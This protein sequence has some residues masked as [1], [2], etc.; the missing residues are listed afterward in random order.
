MKKLMA[1]LAGIGL[2]AGVAN[3]DLLV[4]WDFVGLSGINS[5]SITANVA[6]A[7]MA[8][9]GDMLVDRGA[10]L[11]PSSNTGGYAANNWHSD[12][13][14]LATAI[15]SNNYFSFTLEAAD[16]FHF[17]TTN[18]TWNMRRSGTG[19]SNFVIR[20]SAD[21]FASDL[22]TWTS[23]ANGTL[24]SAVSLGTQTAVEFRLYGYSGT[25]GAG[26]MNMGGSGN[27]VEFYGVTSLIPEPGTMALLAMGLAGV[28][29][30][31][32]RKHIS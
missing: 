30:V 26:A 10:G 7:E 2:T 23:E 28:A 12:D 13:P 5:G 9:P 18:I 11:V 19:P 24:S 31:R 8:A 22:A 6:H 15:A 4:A 21:G 17:T 20:T 32:R 1:I 25:S 3:A 14:S 16:G 29:L 27:D